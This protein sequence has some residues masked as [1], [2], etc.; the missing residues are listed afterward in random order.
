[1]TGLQFGRAAGEETMALLRTFLAL[2]G[3]LA[4]AHAAT[5]RHSYLSLSMDEIV[6]FLAFI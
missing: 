1:M 4:T 2:T 6:F 5:V 3:I